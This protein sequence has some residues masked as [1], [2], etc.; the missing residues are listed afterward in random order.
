[1]KMRF[2]RK[3]FTLIELLVVI[4]VIAL[5]LSVAL[6]ALNKAKEK[7]R[8]VVCQ[9]NLRQWGVV[10]LTYTVD[11]SDKFWVEYM[12][13]LNTQQ[14]QW[15]LTLSPYYDNINKL[16]L[17]A[18]AGKQN[19]V[20]PGIGTGRH[21]WGVDGDDN[22]FVSG[23]GFNRGPDSYRKNYGSYGINRW[24]NDVKPPYETWGK[25]PEW[26]WRTPLHARSS[27]IPM[28]MDCTWYG[29]NPDNP[30]V[31][32]TED[33]SFVET[34]TFWQN[35][36]YSRFNSAIENDISKLLIERHRKGINISLMDGSV[37][38]VDIEDLW[39]LKWHKAFDQNSGK[40]EIPWRSSPRP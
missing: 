25:H 23:Y 32:G 35:I 26:Q 7:T 37:Q 10:F 12:A 22:A 39:S 11:N 34:S 1:M 21:F 33:V 4:A 38:N 27:K 29:V 2:R 36:G 14:G 3:G 24:I 20:F 19:P 8:E 17:C 6:P 40:I 18:S 9:S 16:R 15:M 31:D 13:T 30:T 28:I 5:L